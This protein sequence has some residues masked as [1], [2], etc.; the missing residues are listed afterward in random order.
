F[1]ERDTYKKITIYKYLDGDTLEKSNICSGFEKDCIASE[2]KELFLREG[3]VAEDL[4]AR[5][6]IVTRKG[7]DNVLNLIDLEGYHTKPKR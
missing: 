5:Q 3:I 1:I 2:L 6:F 4:Q 7:N